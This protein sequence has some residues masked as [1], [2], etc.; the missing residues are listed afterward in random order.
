MAWIPQTK[1]QIQTEPITQTQPHAVYKR[2]TLKLKIQIG[3]KLQT[4]KKID[5]I[6]GKHMEAVW[7]Y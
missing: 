7:L 6:N 4:W 1:E 2:C 3:W 5:H